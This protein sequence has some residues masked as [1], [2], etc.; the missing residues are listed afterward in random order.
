VATVRASDKIYGARA[1]TISLM[2]RRTFELL[3]ARSLVAGKTKSTTWTGIIN[4]TVRAD[5]FDILLSG[6]FFDAKMT[7]VNS[8]CQQRLTIVFEEGLPIKKLS[9]LLKKC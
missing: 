5:G 9:A 7:V 6:N 1:R 4:G 3:L 2:E 8:P